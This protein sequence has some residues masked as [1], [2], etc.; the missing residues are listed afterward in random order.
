[1]R[2]H[3]RAVG[4]EGEDLRVPVEGT[5][6]LTTPCLLLDR[7]KL[8]ANV[9]EMQRALARH[10]VPLRQHVKTA[11][12]IDVARVVSGS[13][14]APITVSTLREAEHFAA[15]GFHDH[16]L[17][18]GATPAK[19]ARIAA[20]AR[21]GA[22]VRILV[23]DEDAARDIGD[24]ARAA[25][26]RLEALVEI[27]VGQHRGGVAPDGDALLAIARAVASA[28]MDLVGVLAHGGHSYDARSAPDIARIAEEERSGAVH[29][30]DRLRAAGHAVSVVSVGS[31]P[32][33]LFAERLDGVTEVRAGVFVFQ[34]LFQAALG[35]ARVEDIALS[36]LT[37]VIGVHR[38]RGTVLV[39]AG[40]L[41]LSKDRSLDAIGGRGYGEVTRSD[42]TRMPARPSIAWVNQEHGAIALESLPSVP[43]VGDRL[44]V[45]PNH[46]C[47]TAAMYDRYHVLDAQGRAV[48]TWS[49][50]N[51]F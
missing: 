41:A 1:M 46:A 40:A 13:E 48:E 19:V 23:D 6:G 25:G 11:K 4:V 28:G 15:H 37:T 8:E 51:G 14:H 29:A 16:T 21:S 12:S 36:V 7:G 27:D 30:A 38:D 44:R 5:D 2:E 10:G 9:A 31:T 50:V 49:R 45:L 22:R 18:V 47:M 33:A 26:V 3:G 43:R 17:A 20:L 42:G 24:E 39:D 34:D 32:T 35:C